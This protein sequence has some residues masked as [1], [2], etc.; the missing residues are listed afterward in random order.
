MLA[1]R[2]SN[3]GKAVLDLSPVQREAL[4]SHLRGLA[5][6]EFPTES[7]PC[8]VCDKVHGETLAEKDR[9]GIPF[10]VVICPDCGLIRTNPRMTQEAY[11]SF[12]N[13]D[14]R[15]LYSGQ[16][17]PD[18]AYFRTIRPRAEIIRDFVGRNGLKIGPGSVVIE[19][20]CGAGGILK[21]FQETG[22]HVVGCDLGDE[23]LAYG[24]TV[25]KMD[26]RRG[27][28]RDLELVGQA[29]LIIYSHVIEHVLDVHEEL[30]TIR[31]FL[32]PGGGVYIE[33]PSVKN[34]WKPYQGDFLRILQ[35]AHTYHFSLATLTNLLARGGFRLVAGDE[36][37]HS[38]FKIG[39][40]GS[41][42]NDYPAVMRHLK[43]AELTRHLFPFRK[44]E[45]KKRLRRL[46]GRA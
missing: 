26:L 4:A 24:R 32:K 2:Y 36:A 3:D 38:L 5:A 46:L 39:E 27:F 43:R 34:L 15:A 42:V 25:G 35:N 30:R 23:F 31:R 11:A 8:P 12:Y 16:E 37:T 13:S 29:D 22:A 6:G 20:G 7:R 9:Y 21:I 19:V 10:A 1:A 41:I 18:D 14:Y 45:L 33:V 17:R 44:K 28:L 40:G